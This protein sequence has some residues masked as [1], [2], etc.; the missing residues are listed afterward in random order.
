M[1]NVVPFGGK[2]R[3]KATFDSDFTEMLKGVVKIKKESLIPKKTA[4]SI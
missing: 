4:S 3:N 1:G 2:E